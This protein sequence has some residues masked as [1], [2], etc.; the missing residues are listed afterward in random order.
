LCACCA[1]FSTSALIDH[2]GA[3]TNMVD[4]RLILAAGCPKIAA[5]QTMGSLPHWAITR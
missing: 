2:Y 4:L 1:A 5:N 3:D